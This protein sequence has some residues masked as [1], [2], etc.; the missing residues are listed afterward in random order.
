MSNGVGS[1]GKG[2]KFTV[3]VQSTLP[4]SDASWTVDL[5]TDPAMA[6]LYTNL[7]YDLIAAAMAKL[8]VEMSKYVLDGDK[9]R[10]EG[11]ME[12]ASKAMRTGVV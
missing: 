12:V 1:A 3:Q 9:D 10:L 2:E 11:A 4:L 6:L 5:T 7:G 8:G